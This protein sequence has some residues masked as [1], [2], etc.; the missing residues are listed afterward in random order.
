MRK[1]FWVDAFLEAMFAERSASSNTIEAYERDLARFV[2]HLKEKDMDLASATEADLEAYLRELAAR[3]YA[4]S[5][6]SRHLSALRQFYRFAHAEGWLKNDPTHRIKNPKL[7]RPLP[8]VITAEEIDRMLS[9][10]RGM[11]QSGRANARNA[12]LFELMYATGA[13]V[14]EVARLPAA[15]VRGSPRF[16]MVLGKGNKERLVPLVEPARLAIEAW[17]EFRDQ[18]E[19][20][21]RLEGKQPSIYLFPSRGKSGHLTRHRIYS[22]IKELAVAANV[23]PE[24]V[25]PHGIRHAVATHLLE[26]G[27]DLRTIQSILGHADIA[28]TEIYTHVAGKHLQELVHTRHPLA[29][30]QSGP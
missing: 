27:A 17:L 25:S 2:D 3:G 28:T 29:S 13:R 14:S 16:L 24:K 9:A 26:N 22:L 8:E 15:S 10:A 23:P 4:A 21:R 19:E 11:H 6:R 18:T 7:R 12:C 1:D 30:Q 20:L 5:T